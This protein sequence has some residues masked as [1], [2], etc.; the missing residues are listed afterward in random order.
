MCISC[1]LVSHHASCY[2]NADHFA[3]LRKVS[4]DTPLAKPYP[5]DGICCSSIYDNRACDSIIVDFGG[6][7]FTWSANTMTP[8]RPKL[9]RRIFSS[10]IWFEYEKGHITE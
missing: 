8:V 10:S 2:A 4:S 9:L 7:L 6:V 3:T 5:N 1:R